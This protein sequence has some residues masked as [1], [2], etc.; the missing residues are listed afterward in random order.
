MKLNPSV[1]MIDFQ[2]KD[3]R[4]K[5]MQILSDLKKVGKGALPDHELVDELSKVTMEFFGLRINFIFTPSNF[6]PCIMLPSATKNNP[7]VFPEWI[8]MG[9]IAFS[10]H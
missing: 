2:S 5:Y 10:R 8:E 6:G 4:D 9:R 1:E 7:L 3:K